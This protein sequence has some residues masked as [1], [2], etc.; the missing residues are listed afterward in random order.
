M[1]SKTSFYSYMKNDA[2]HR[3]WVPALSCVVFFFVVIAVAMA[4]QNLRNA[5]Q[6]EV[7]QMQQA[8]DF[9]ESIFSKENIFLTLIAAV[10][11]TICGLEGFSYLF[12]R[13]KTDY[14]H[15]LPMKR[16]H[17]FFLRWLGSLLFY[18]VPYILCMVICTI[19][20]GGSG[21][22]THMYYQNLWIGF[23]YNLVV[24]LLIYHTAILAVMLTGQILVAIAGFGILL[25][26]TV[27]VNYLVPIYVQSF[28]RTYDTQNMATLGFLRYLSP[29]HV[30]VDLTADGRFVSWLAAILLM[31]AMLVASFVLYRLRPSEAAGNSITFPVSRPV[32][33]I[34][35]VIP[36]SLYVALAFHEIAEW[37]SAFWSIFG[38]AIF[39]LLIHAL[40]EIIYDFDIRSAL[41]HWPQLAGCFLAGLA[42]L[43]FFLTDPLRLD[44]RLPAINNVSAVYLDLPLDN[45]IP[46]FHKSDLLSQTPL[47]SCNELSMTSYRLEHTALTGDSLQLAYNLIRNAQKISEN[48]N[49]YQN[50]YQANLNIAF[51]KKNGSLEYRNF[52]LWL[53]ANKGDLME[54]YN[55][56]ELRETHFQIVSL[57]SDIYRSMAV[58]D[59]AENTFSRN[60]SEAEISEFID[61]YKRELL[62]QTAE[63]AIAYPSIGQLEL[64]TKSNVVLH[65]YQIY[66]SFTDTLAWLKDHT[67]DLNA[68]TRQMT[69]ASI[70]IERE[71]NESYYSNG[72][73]E[74]EVYYEPEFTEDMADEYEEGT[75]VLDEG[76]PASEDTTAAETTATDEKG[77]FFPVTITDPQRIRS[78][79][80]HLYNR[81]LYEFNDILNE[82]NEIQYVV[83]VSFKDADTASLY[84]MEFVCDADFDMDAYLAEGENADGKQ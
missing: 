34:L 62:E 26:Y 24:F 67:I 39:A 66:S 83:N 21:L 44:S 29:L 78:L 53:P 77:P 11:A 70:T 9:A 71:R 57:P 1:T 75:H 23:L 56:R 19:L 42:F 69:P 12:S 84:N 13:K 31:A 36:F 76:S 32:I 27:I 7:Y 51:R 30:W 20:L 25:S 41:H 61:I 58:K 63:D 47:E 64:T 43:G 18:L 54:V 79:L 5:M 68:W 3:L 73:Y 10:G 14:F 50:L 65:A 60:F 16:E 49:G 74:D 8:L 15:S 37:A 6:G 40:I 45:N 48:D 46:Y 28:Y 2:R 35:L 80:S 38:L 52:D 17:L 33:R 22:T 82:K 72:Y 59:A 81:K 55:M 4:S